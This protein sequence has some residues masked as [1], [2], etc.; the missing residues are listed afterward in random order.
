VTKLKTANSQGWR[1]KK[2]QSTIT[3]PIAGVRRL[4]IL[5]E[6]VEILKSCFSSTFIISRLLSNYQNK[7]Q[8][9]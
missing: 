2:K 4:R 3:A 7:N 6:L 5:K 8:H 1:K 9:S